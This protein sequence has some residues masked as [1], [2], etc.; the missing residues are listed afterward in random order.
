M[1]KMILYVLLS[2]I[3]FYFLFALLKDF[4]YRVIK[5]KICAICGAV[6]LTWIILLILKFIG[7][8]IESLLLGILLG[9]SV[10]GIMYYL[11]DKIKNKLTLSFVRLSTILIGT[12][13][14]YSLLNV[15]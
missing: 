2:I 5:I 3:L 11:E 1:V 15:M 13:V 14:V 6:S 4:I 12:L 10:V 9:Q 8:E 7:Y